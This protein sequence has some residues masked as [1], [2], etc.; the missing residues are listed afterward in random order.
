M[1]QI[2]GRPSFL[3]IDQS[4][5]APPATAKQLQTMRDLGGHPSDGLSFNEARMGI[6]A[7]RERRGRQAQQRKEAA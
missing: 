3:Q 4:G 1:S 5:F 6:K 2:P 7:L